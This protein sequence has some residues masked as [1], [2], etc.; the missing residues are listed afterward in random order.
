MRGLAQTHGSWR[1][2]RGQPSAPGGLVY[3][4]AGGALLR[5]QAHVG[6]RGAFSRLPRGTVRT[7]RAS[8]GV[9]RLRAFHPTGDAGLPERERECAAGTG[10]RAPESCSLRARRAP[11]RARSRPSSAG[12]GSWARR[13]EGERWHEMMTMM[14][15]G[16]AR[17]GGGR[18]CNQQARRGGRGRC[19]RATACAASAASPGPGRG[20]P[21]VLSPPLGAGGLSFLGP[22]RLKS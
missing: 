15:V 5:P 6:P 1:R 18:R 21:P 22:R 20:R 13:T 17:P 3:R 19:Q 16:S 11:R 10:A 2:V 4:A 14:P 7:G 9:Q 8:G 12:V